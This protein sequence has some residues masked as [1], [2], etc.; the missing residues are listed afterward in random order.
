MRSTETINVDC[1]KKG[2]FAHVQNHV[3]FSLIYLTPEASLHP[4]L[5]CHQE[6][7]EM[8]DVAPCLSGNHDT[9]DPW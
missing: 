4:L 7:L 3:Q 6:A 5:N 1:M 2:C 8:P 9:L